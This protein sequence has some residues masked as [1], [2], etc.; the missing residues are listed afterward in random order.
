MNTLLDD[1]YRHDLHNQNFIERKASLHE[2]SVWICGVAQSGK[3]SLIKQYLL[4]HKKST[5]LYLDCR[6]LRLNIDELNLHL[7]PFCHEHKISI[8]ALDNYVDE[9][10]LFPLGQIILASQHPNITAF[11]T[12]RLNLLDFEE[13]LAFE[14]KYDSTALNHFFILGGFPAMHK[15]PSEERSLYLQKTLSNT[16]NDIEMSLLLQASKMVTQKVSAFTL[17]ERLKTE[18]KIS[19]DKLYVSLQSLYDKEYLYG[20]EKWGHPSAIKKLYLCDIAIKNALVIQKHF[21]K[22]FENLVFLELIKHGVEC[23]YEEGI[24]FYLPQ[25]NQIILASPFANEHA[26]FKKVEALEGFIIAYQVQEV[27][28]VTMNLENVLSHPISRIEM[29]PFSQ[30]ALGEE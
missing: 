21:G 6:D 27:I 19:K 26:L 5:Y 22:V 13:F 4:T 23:Y 30:W 9:I 15:T 3:T 11:E 17:Y 24:D 10:N 1:Y 25:R 28:V 20:C 14:P 8:L 2:E 29:V 12:L 16:L 7:E 18:R